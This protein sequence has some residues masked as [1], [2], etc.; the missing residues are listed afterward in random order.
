MLEN[1]ITLGNSLESS[2]TIL[3]YIS[4]AKLGKTKSILAIVVDDNSYQ[5]ITHEDKKSNVS[6]IRKYLYSAGP[7]NGADKTPTSLITVPHKTFNK[8]ILKWFDMHKNKDILLDK[9]HKI[10]ISNTDQIIKDI[11]KEKK[12]FQ[13]NVIKMYFL[14]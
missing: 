3:N 7:S 13:K 8:K 10:L 5:G 1:I 6:E 4:I 12:I 9:I 14:Q 11:Q 2:D